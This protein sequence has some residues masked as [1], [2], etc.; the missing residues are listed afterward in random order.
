MNKIYYSVAAISIA[1]TLSLSTSCMKKETNPFLEEYTTEYQIP[2][3]DKIK[4]EH[5]IP[6]F[7]KGI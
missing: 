2:P 4:A 6:A 1:A 3:F 7:E 5:Y